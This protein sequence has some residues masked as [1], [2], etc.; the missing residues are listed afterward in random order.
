MGEMQNRRSS[1]SMSR[2]SCFV[3]ISF[4]LLQCVVDADEC[5]MSM[6]DVLEY[7]YCVYIC[8]DGALCVCLIFLVVIGCVCAEHYPMFLYG[9]RLIIDESECIENH[10]F[11][12]VG[13]GG[14]FVRVCTAGL[15]LSVFCICS[16]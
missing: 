9:H 11:Q 8:D 6:I 15:R 4:N 3:I 7:V 13:V 1:S 16:E 5:S 12:C 2:K 10:V 14:E